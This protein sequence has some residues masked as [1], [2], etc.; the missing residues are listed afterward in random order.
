ILYRA[1]TYFAQGRSGG[2]IVGARVPLVLLSRAEPP[3]TKIHSISLALVAIEHQRQPAER[4]KAV[5]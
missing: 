1:I 2:I 3:E 5:G 4:P